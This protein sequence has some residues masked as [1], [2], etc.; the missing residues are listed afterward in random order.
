MQCGGYGRLGIA[1]RT[2]RPWA[3]ANVKPLLV[4][5]NTV[6][7]DHREKYRGVIK[8]ELHKEVMPYWQEQRVQRAAAKQP[9]VVMPPAPKPLL[10]PVEP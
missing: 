9:T 2:T 10:Q 7:N 3:E 8:R 5:H 4:L 1:R 6:C